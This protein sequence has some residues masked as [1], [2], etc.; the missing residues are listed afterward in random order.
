MSKRD[1]IQANKD[2]LEAKS[3]E[4]VKKKRL[5][6][7]NLDDFAFLAKTYLM[8]RDRANYSYYNYLKE[9]GMAG[10][11]KPLRNENGDLIIPLAIAMGISELIPVDDHQ[12]E[13][14]YQRA[15]SKSMKIIRE[16][17]DDAVFSQLYK[18]DSR[19]RFWPAIWGKLGKYA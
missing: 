16:T 6:E 3:K 2:W 15:W 9:Y 8:K 19:K 13:K 7:L 12:T 1:Y 5:S 11:K 17:G 14:E 10:S 4:E 18:L